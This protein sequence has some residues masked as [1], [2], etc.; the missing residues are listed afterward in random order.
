MAEDVECK[1]TLL[2]SLSTARTYYVPGTGLG[3]ADALENGTW[4]SGDLHKEELLMKV[5]GA[6]GVT[7]KYSESHRRLGKGAGGAR[8][9]PGSEGQIGEW[10]EEEGHSKQRE[11]HSEV[12]SPLA[13][14]WEWTL[15][16][17]WGCR[18]CSS[19]CL[20]GVSWMRG[21]SGSIPLGACRHSVLSQEW[22]RGVGNAPR[23]RAGKP[24]EGRAAGR[25]GS[26][27]AQ[28]LPLV[29]E[30]GADDGCWAF[31]A[32]PLADRDP[33]T[34]RQWRIRLQ[35]QRL[36]ALPQGRHSAGVWGSGSASSS[37]CKWPPSS[38]KTLPFQALKHHR[39]Q[40]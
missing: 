1:L 32:V 29:L 34:A 23:R 10:P 3:A 7:A 38:V 6:L 21:L 11:Q 9:Q 18:G 2:H 25:S 27:T 5:S 35:V 24:E 19:G 33:N 15:P 16:G 4:S 31:S 40:G 39:Q 12:L 36:A 8:A 13:G 20:E 30:L 26:V 22:R 28:T 14:T 37:G 17:A